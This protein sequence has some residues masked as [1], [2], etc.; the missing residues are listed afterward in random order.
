MEVWLKDSVEISISKIKVL[1]GIFLCILMISASITVI[2]LRQNLL[3]VIIGFFG[4]FVCSFGLII[5]ISKLFYFKPLVF[6]NSEGIEDLRLKCGVIRWSDVEAVTIEATR[7][8]SWISVYAKSP[9]KYYSKLS[10]YQ[11]FL[12]KLN[13]QPGKNDFR[14]RFVELDK[15]IDEAFDLIEHI[16]KEGEHDLSLA[17]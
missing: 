6:I 9:E 12:R 15:P 5:Q 3:I 1:R 4:A 16:L 17:P 13:G 7:H 14:I 11:L 10:K 2:L 8:V